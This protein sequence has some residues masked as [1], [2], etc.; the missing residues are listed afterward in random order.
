[1]KN[2]SQ[3]ITSNKTTTTAADNSQS[4]IYV[5]NKGNDKNTGSKTSPK[6]TIKN[7]LKTVT[8]GGTIHLNSGTYYENGIF[9]NKNV[10]IESDNTKTTIIDAQKKHVFTID[11]NTKVTFKSFTITNAKD[12]NGAAIY[13]KG[14]L[15]L[16][17]MKISACNSS[18]SGAVY[19]KGSV[20]CIKT[21]FSGNYAKKGAA[22]YN[23][24]YL[25]SKYST[26]NKNN[27]ETQGSAIFTSGSG[28]SVLISNNF[29][30]NRNSAVYFA[31]K[32]DNEIRDSKFISNIAING[33][34]IY[35]DGVLRINK[36]YF[37]LNNA[38]QHGG[39]IYNKNSLNIQNSTFKVN[40]AKENGGAIYST[41]TLNILD[42]TL[43]NNKAQ[44][45]AAVSNMKT[46][47]VKNTQ[48]S[49]NK[50][51][52]HGGAIYN[53]LNNTSKVTIKNSNFTNNTANLGAGIYSYG[54]VVVTINASN[55]NANNN[56]AA[57]FKTTSDTN[58]I[59]DSNFSKND[60]AVYIDGS[61][62]NIFK[63]VFSA[64]TDTGAAVN[65]YKGKVFIRD[66]VLKNNA[67]VDIFNNK[68]KIIADY[69]WW[70]SNNNPN[71][72][73]N[74]TTINYWIYLTFKT[75]ANVE[76]KTTTSVISLNNV[77][78]GKTVISHTSDLPKIAAKYSAS[79]CGV[80]TTQMITLNNAP[81]SI[82]TQ[83]KN[84]GNATVGIDVDA[85]VIKNSV[86]LEVPSKIT[87]LFVQ[88]GASVSKST[89]D[90]WKKAG[91]TD[92]YVQARA[93]TD[94]YAKLK[95][96]VSLTRGSNIRVHAWVICFSTSHGFDISDKQQTMIK[97]FI[98]KVI[99]IDGVRGVCLDYVRYSGSNPSSVVPSKITNFVKAVN[100]IVKSNDPT[101]TVSACVF[102]EKAGTKVYYGQDYAAMSPYVDVMLPMAYKYD[103]HA[104]RNWLK[105]VTAYV[106]KEAKYSKVVTVLQTYKEGSKITM[107]PKS[108]LTDDAK[109][110]MSVGSCGYSLFRYGLISGYPG[111]A[112]LLA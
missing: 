41:S 1:M 21:S 22:I 23:I 48:F 96:V 97:N 59:T 70:G 7:A 71:T 68:G 35:N 38:T 107:L 94:N 77:Y 40:S 50:A 103:Y 13:N 81:V 16:E 109:A 37:N 65:N 61:T 111:S 101:K 56:N 36:T 54:D 53:N 98:S 8:N 64:N 31:S 75:T 95:E 72:R 4:T 82:K 74:G 79:G 26:F 87:S 110:V 32:K 102:A 9:I 90:T 78:D 11:F 91:I 112:E 43:E 58:T 2:T 69:N 25:K 19:N 57:Y 108:E 55:F 33:G 39:A 76:N 88:I 29:T 20:E 66:S 47:T 100:S 84:N 67:K 10:K 99:K 73:V 44:K 52:V 49:L 15:K 28:K 42:S 85:Q 106:V 93:S 60:R 24:N 104:G 6:A 51:T 18:I 27:V 3:S 12:T 83:F 45:G 86:N 30:S 63:S 92:V 14:T 62:V 80:T 34:A 5:S 105:D 46:L 17:A 89:V